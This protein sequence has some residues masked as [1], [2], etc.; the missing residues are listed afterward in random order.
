MRPFRVMLA[1]P[2]L[3]EEPYS[4]LHPT[5]GLLYLAGAV[6]NVFSHQDVDVVYQKGFCSLEEH[7]KAIA[8]YK[9]DLYAISFKSPVA[10]LGCQTTSAV[11]AAFPRLPIVAGGVHATAMPEDVLDNSSVDACFRGECE[12]TFV[13]LIRSWREGPYRFENS[14]GAVFRQGAEYVHN[15]APP[16]TKDIDQ[17][18]WPAWDLVDNNTFPGMAYEREPALGV[19]VSRGCPWKCTFCSEPIWKINGNPTFRARSPKDVASEVE[20][21]YRRGIR[22]VRLWCEELNA[23]VKWACEVLEAIAGL[24]HRDLF[25]NSNIRSDH[26]TVELADAMRNANLRL[27]CTGIES[28]SQRTL[29]ALLKSCKKEQVEHACAIL[30]SRGIKVLGYFL[31]YAAWEIE[32]RLEFE[33]TQ[34]A[35]RTIRYAIQLHHRGLLDYVSVGVATP[36]PSAP[37]WD[38]AK[39]Y[40]LF[41][42]PSSQPFY[43]V[44]EGM[45]LPGISRAEM[46]RTLL[47][48]RAAQSWIALR[49]GSYKWRAFSEGIR[50]FVRPRRVA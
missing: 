5:F 49:S 20:Y 41:R 21:L 12:Q 23:N 48:A 43:Y 34:E 39:K 22:E 37:M 35:M 36:R 1:D 44:E 13:D 50:K 9:P 16:L 18:A 10:R 8:D 28:S 15:C 33:G 46:R 14:A 11:R 47:I 19:V 42:M 6:R 27:V 3:R 2:P 30:R 29:D 17:L 7:L 38:V 4:Y 45:A 24:G 31:L 40:N 32:G 26:V 25:L